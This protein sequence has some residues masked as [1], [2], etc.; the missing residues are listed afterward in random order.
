M[1]DKLEERLAAP[2]SM[3]EELTEDQYRKRVEDRRKQ[4]Q[5]VVGKSE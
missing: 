5:F 4:S 3:F 2:Q 1:T